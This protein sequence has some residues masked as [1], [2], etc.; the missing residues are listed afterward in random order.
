MTPRPLLSVIIATRDRAAMLERCLQALENQ[1]QPPQTFEVIVSD[2]GSRDTTAQLL[3]RFDP[4]FPLRVTE[5]TGEGQAV[6]QNRAIHLAAGDICLLLDDDVVAGPHVIEAHL[7]VHTARAR[8]LAIGKLVQ[9]PPENGD[10]YARSFAASWNRHF[11][12]LVQRPLDWAACYGGNL[13][14]PRDE[15]LAVGGVATDLERGE[16]FELAYRLTLRG[17]RP[18]YVPEAEA[19][20]VDSKGARHLIR[21]ARA[22]GQSQV[23]LTRHEPKMMPRLLGG[24]G[25]TTRREIWLRRLMIRTALSSELLARLGPLVPGADRRRAWFDF[26]SR[27]A[28]WQGVRQ[29]MNGDGWS[30][31][32]AGIPVLMY[33]AFGAEDEDDRYVVRARS[34]SRQMHLL[35]LLRYKVISF[36]NLVD[37]R[38]ASRLPPRR[39]LVITIDDGYRDNLQV[40]YPIFRRFGFP[41]TIF[42]VTR[43]LGHTNDWTADG[44]LAGRA[45]LSRLE[46]S[47]MLR[48]GLVTLGAHSRTHAWLT[49]LTEPQMWDEVSGSR[50]DLWPELGSS[51]ESFAYPYGDLDVRAVAAAGQAGFSG[52]CTTEPRLSTPAD[53]C[54]RVPRIEI[55]GGDSLLKFLLKLRGLA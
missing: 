30:R 12:S 16:D 17:C 18:V 2:D 41:V 48:D 31:L 34:L 37:A 54:L 13:S 42:V 5:G 6:A 11:E 27:L 22:Q 8:S 4:A 3:G 45:L 51:P 15:L 40:A 53:D 47:D 26:V 24:F 33:H 7:R 23:G 10:W 44:A 46:L 14:V 36:E 20:H 43:R 39:S 25:D 35:R 9:L 21:D 1:S 50:R 38:R 32:T 52:A 28:F 19:L 49:R 55:M 29:A